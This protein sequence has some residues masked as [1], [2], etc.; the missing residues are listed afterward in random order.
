MTT[1]WTQADYDALKQAIATGANSVSYN[2]QR[3]EYRD[4]HQM[5]ALLSEMEGELGLKTRKRRSRATFK[6]GL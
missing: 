2:G 3:V 4:L 1:R 6:R 5:K